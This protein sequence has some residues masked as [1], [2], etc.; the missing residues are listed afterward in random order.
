MT[1]AIFISLLTSAIRLATPLL[2]AALAGVFSER[3]GVVNIGLEGLMIMGAF[4]SVWFTHMTGSAWIGVLAGV[5][6]G[7][8]ASGLLAVIAINLKG[9]QIIAGT[10]LNLL[11]VALVAFLLEIIWHRSGSTPTAPAMLTTNP[12]KFLEGIPLL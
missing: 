8:V 5:L 2:L 3:S 6:F 9:N 7:I 4:F 1:S 11:T 12:L 10:A